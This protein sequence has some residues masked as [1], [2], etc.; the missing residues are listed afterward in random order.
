MPPPPI[1]EDRQK[2]FR[3]AIEEAL[4]EGYD[5]WRQRDGGRGSSVEEAARRLAASGHEGGTARCVSLAINRWLRWADKRRAR[6]EDVAW[7]DWSLYARP[8]KPAAA[9]AARRVE[10]WLLTAAQDDTDVHPRFLSNLLAYAQYLGAR[11]LVAGFT[12]QH[13]IHTDRLTK[14]ATY[15][16][17]IRDF[18]RFDPMDCGAVLFCAEMNTLPTAQRPLSDLLTYSRGR[19]AVFPHA[20]HALE[21]VPVPRGAV[22]VQVMTTGAVTVPNYIEKKAGLKAQFHHIL[23]AVIV[24]ATADGAWCR[25]ISAEPD[26]SFQDLDRRVSGGHV[27]P[28]ERAWAVTLGDVHAPYADEGIT[29]WL[30]GTEADSLIEALRP[31]F[32]FLQDLCDF[33]PINRHSGACPHH[34][35]RMFAARE[36]CV[37][38][39]VRAGARVV[40]EVERP[41]LVPVVVGSNHDAWLTLWARNP[42]GHADPENAAYWHRCN[43]AVHQAIAA[44]DDGFDL[45]RW[46]LREADARRLEGVDFVPA[47]GSHVILQDR[48]GGIECGAHGHEGPNGSRGTA[49]A[50]SRVATRMNTGH[51]HSP[52]IVD[53]VFQAGVTGHLDQGY[54]RGPSGWAH[55]HVITYPNAKRAIVVQAPDGRW[56][57]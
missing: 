7:P 1:S 51:A 38:D 21:A 56:R 57:A 3:R 37:E 16:P 20:K 49:R 28:G 9:I 11:L 29:R 47:G 39:H 43:L 14:T 5:P 50:L 40:R 13:V 22:P 53:G 10:R 31:R 32:A 4:R 15:R 42:G 54:N 17:E 34:R 36:S 26:G 24:E 48:G 45:F 44:G 41:W 23:G 6:G 46:A 19:T 8:G 35:A 18:L 52:A 55:A 25:H 12:Y 30:W 27:S 2:R 33:R